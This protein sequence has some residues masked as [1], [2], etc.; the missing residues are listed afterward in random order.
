MKHSFKIMTTVV[1]MCTIMAVM[2]VGIWAAT[3][4]DTKV[5]AYLTFTAQDVDVQFIGRISGTA[6]PTNDWIQN[7]SSE[8][9][10][11]TSISWAIGS[12]SFD[13]QTKD[14]I[15]IGIAMRNNGIDTKPYCVTNISTNLPAGVTMTY[16]QT[17]GI[18]AAPAATVYSQSEFIPSIISSLSASAAETSASGTVPP[19]YNPAS[20]NAMATGKV[21]YF[22]IVFTLNNWDSDI[23]PFSVAFGMNIASS[24]IS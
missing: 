9:K 14:S 23:E 12:L 20:T 2:M 8:M 6:T 5:S 21:F 17:G 7:I 3:S 15:K 24:K 1:A 4:Q 16:R 19:A 11:S 22:E 18:T 13:G 10:D